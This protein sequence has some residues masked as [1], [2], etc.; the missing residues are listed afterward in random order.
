MKQKIGRQNVLYP[1]PVAVVGALV[2]GKANFCN[3]S[4][5]GILNAAEPHFIMLSMGRSH[6]TNAGIREQRTFS[7]NLMAARDMVRADHVGL[8]SGVRTDKS[9]VFDVFFGELKTAPLIRDCPLS[10]EC[11][12]HDVYEIKTHEIFI[13][14]IMATYA[15]EAVLTDGEADLAKVDPLLFDMTSKR[16]WSVGSPVGDCWKAGKAYKKE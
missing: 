16:Y 10:M 1:T 14:E 4:H 15:D 13:G 12:L 6:H 11:R 8:V 9:G 3:I 5:N 2:Q 7:V